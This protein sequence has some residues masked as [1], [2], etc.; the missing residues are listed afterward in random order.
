MENGS[1]VE[2]FFLLPWDEAAHLMMGGRAVKLWDV[3][4]LLHLP[5]GTMMRGLSAG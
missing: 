1:I 2:G 5:P 4:I 3:C